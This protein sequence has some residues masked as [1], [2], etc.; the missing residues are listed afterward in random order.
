MLTSH[1]SRCRAPKTNYA[2]VECEGCLQH[3]SAVRSSF[4][5]QFP[6]AS[7]SDI[8]YA[9][10][11]KMEERTA[12]SRSNYQDPRGFSRAGERSTN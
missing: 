6:K 2:D 11:Q 12:H 9:V 7:E 8:L 4:V 1:C 3:R 5:E 10:R